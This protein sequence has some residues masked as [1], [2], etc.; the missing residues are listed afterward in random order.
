MELVFGNEML[1]FLA[2]RGIVCAIDFIA[3]EREGKTDNYLQSCS[4]G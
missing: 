1:T 4:G 3:N 2:A